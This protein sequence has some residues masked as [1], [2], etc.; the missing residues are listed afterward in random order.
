MNETLAP[1]LRKCAI[2]FFDDILVYSQLFEEHQVHL[3]QVLQLLSENHWKVKT[4][5]CT[6][7][8]RSV[9]YLGYVVDS[10]GVST[11]PGKIVD[12]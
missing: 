3:K 2:V 7:A 4:S 1:V 5:K 6:F 11:D 10:R 8:Q 9:A 12:I